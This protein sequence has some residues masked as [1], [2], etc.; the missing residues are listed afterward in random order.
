MIKAIRLIMAVVGAVKT[1]KPWVE[2]VINTLK[3]KKKQ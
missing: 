2:L 3:R 1:V